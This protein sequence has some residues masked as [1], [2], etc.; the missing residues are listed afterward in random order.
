MTWPHC[1]LAAPRIHFHN[2]IIFNFLSSYAWWW[3]CWWFHSLTSMKMIFDVVQCSFCLFASTSN[4]RRWLLEY[5]LP[6]SYIHILSGCSWTEKVKF[7][8]TG[9]LLYKFSLSRILL[10]WVLSFVIEKTDENVKQRW[11]RTDFRFFM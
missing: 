10:S 9:S 3:R 4:N 1:R 2:L 11:Y 5:E 8:I 7:A 6:F